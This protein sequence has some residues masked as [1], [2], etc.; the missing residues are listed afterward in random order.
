[1]STFD[2]F[3]RV[4][5]W[6]N[7]IQIL[8]FLV[9]AQLLLSILFNFFVFF[10]FLL[11]L[12]FLLPFLLV[13]SLQT[14]VFVGTKDK[15]ALFIPLDVAS[16]IW[17]FEILGPFSLLTLL[18][19]LVFGCLGNFSFFCKRES[20]NSFIQIIY[21]VVAIHATNFILLSKIFLHFWVS[22]LR[23]YN[24]SVNSLISLNFF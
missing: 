14:Y 13:K 7:W 17:L 18:V 6:V 16:T 21:W 4:N 22:W 8:H 24:L 2:R 15:L 11:S 5:Q 12:L 19:K 10:Q 9:L 20:Q 23:L 3:K 1:M